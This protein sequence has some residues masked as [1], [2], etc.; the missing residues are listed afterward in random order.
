MKSVS[1]FIVTLPKE[2]LTLML[3]FFFLHMDTLG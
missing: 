2:A 3:A 1:V